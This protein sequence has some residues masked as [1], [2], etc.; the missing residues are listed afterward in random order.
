MPLRHGRGSNPW[1]S[2]YETDTLPLGHRALFSRGSFGMW[3]KCGVKSSDWL[4]WYCYQLCVF[5]LPVFWNES[6]EKLGLKF[7]H[8]VVLEPG[9]TV[10]DTDSVSSSSKSKQVHRS[11]AAERATSKWHKYFIKIIH[12]RIIIKNIAF[13]RLKQLLQQQQ[14]IF[15]LD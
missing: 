10:S 9:L 8:I 1:S 15:W 13:R 12:K 5:L 6:G 14:I 3:K 2:V 4:F 7:D 11:P